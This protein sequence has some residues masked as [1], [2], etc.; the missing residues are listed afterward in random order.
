MNKINITYLVST[1]GRSGPTNQ[2]YNLVSFL[3][4][5]V[6]APSILTLSPEPK[7]TRWVDFE[8]LNITLGSLNLGRV[9]SLVYGKHQ[10]PRLV[11]KFHTD[12]LH[13]HGF[14]ADYVNSI[15]DSLPSRVVTQRNNPFV[16]YPMYYGKPLG[17]FMANSHF[18]ILKR[19]PYVVACSEAL[20]NMNNQKGLNTNAIQNGVLN[21]YLGEIPS[22]QQKLNAKKQL[23]LPINSLLYIWAGP[24]ISRKTPD[25][26]IRAFSRLNNKFNAHLCLLGEGPLLEP[27]KT[28]ATGQKNISFHGAVPNIDDYLIAADL[29]ISS[30]KSEG[31]PN[32]VLEALAWGVPVILSDIPAHREIINISSK[33]GLTFPID[34]EDQLS[35]ILSEFRPS[36]EASLSARSIIET[37][38]NAP[39]M[40]SKYEAMYKS[41]INRHM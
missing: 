2:L 26:V 11:S 10:L 18:R 29:F 25:H 9:S 1:L 39:A 12:I 36:L 16:D 6:F 7:D 19:I 24:F 30:S 38:L 31:L 35:Y 4:P 34:D 37:K 20:S 13:S 22:N 15:F 3:N 28:M 5:L 40:V 23:G 8:K 21:N 41:I 33:A 27:C 32:S 14:R 17:L